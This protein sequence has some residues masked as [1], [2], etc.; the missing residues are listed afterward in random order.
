MARRIRPHSR[1]LLVILALVVFA[2]ACSQSNTPETWAAAQEDGNLRPNFIRACTEANEEGGEVEF[3]ATEA[4]N[5][6]GCAFEE[7][8]E[9]FG[10]A[11]APNSVIS[12]VATAVEGRNFDAFKTLESDLRKNPEQIP[13]DIEAMLKGCA[14][15]AAG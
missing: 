13:V 2:S 5:Y 4:A 6:C 14:S 7:I 15:R 10:G 9:Y 3:S 1:L 11:I 8:V 12:D